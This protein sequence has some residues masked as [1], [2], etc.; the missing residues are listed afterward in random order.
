MIRCFKYWPR[1][2]CL[3]LSSGCHNYGR[4]VAF[5]VHH[6]KFL[7]QEMMKKHDKDG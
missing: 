2:L 3:F 5:K 1:K 6:T 7:D 4:C